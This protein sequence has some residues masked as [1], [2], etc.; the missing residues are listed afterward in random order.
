MLVEVVVFVNARNSVPSGGQNI[1]DLHDVN[2]ESLFPASG[3][4]G[5]PIRLP[6]VLAIVRD[7]ALDRGE[8]R[9]LSCEYCFSGETHTISETGKGV[10][11]IHVLNARQC[12]FWWVLKT[13]LGLS[14]AK[15]RERQGCGKCKWL[16]GFHLKSRCAASFLK[17][18]GRTSRHGQRPYP[19]LLQ[20]LPCAPLIPVVQHFVI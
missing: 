2:F 11:V 4:P 5:W 8:W 13:G 3:W 16:Y 19:I 20:I 17:M 6:K 7:P 9:L 14:K 18:W 12:F 15:G 1:D 10:V